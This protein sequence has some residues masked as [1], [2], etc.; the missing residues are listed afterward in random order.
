[1][2]KK[3]MMAMILTHDGLDTCDYICMFILVSSSERILYMK[4][5]CFQIF[6]F[7]YPLQT[8]VVMVGCR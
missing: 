3:E 7:Y 6:F 2:K 5:N 1:M 8:Q 4:Y